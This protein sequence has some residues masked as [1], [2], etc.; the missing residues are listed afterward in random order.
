MT[1]VCRSCGGTYTDTTPAGGVYAHACPAEIRDKAGNFVPTP[2]PRNENLAVNRHRIETGIKAEGE[3][4]RC[5]T[6]PT[7]TEPMWITS[8]KAS[9]AKREVTDND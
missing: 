1:W 9:I 6:D 2:N 3:G 5:T 4:T 8:F 7:L